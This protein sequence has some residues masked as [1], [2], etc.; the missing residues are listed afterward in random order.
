MDAKLIVIG[1]KANKSEVKLKLPTT[2]GR[3]RKADL[4]V[5]H[6]KVSRHHCEIFEREGV[7]MVKDF[8]SLNGTFIENNRI[9]ESVLKPGDKLTVGP[10]TFV[11]VYEPTGP[12]PA[13]LPNPADLPTPEIGKIEL[14]TTNAK[15]GRSAADT[16][17][18][19]PRRPSPIP[20]VPSPAAPED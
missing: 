4:T 17:S 14:P 20:I 7:L 16:V 13:D 11:A 10:L 19:R 18:A 15:A 8:G 3:S 1:G 12:I 2:I 5:A 9:T 6:P